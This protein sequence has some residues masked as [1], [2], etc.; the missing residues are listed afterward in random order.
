MDD[1]Q[2]N[3]YCMFM[4]LSQLATFLVPLSG[5]AIPIVMWS[6]KK[7]LSPLIDGNGKAIVNFQ[8]SLLIYALCSVVLMF[9]FIGFLLLGALALGA[10]IL[11]VLGAMKAND[12]VVYEYPLTIKFLK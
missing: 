3:Q 10:I 12:G 9:I 5:I 8:L 7:D 11:T 1:K 4:H 2:I 6:L